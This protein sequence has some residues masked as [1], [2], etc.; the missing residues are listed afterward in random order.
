MLHHLKIAVTQIAFIRLRMVESL[1]SQSK[2]RSAWLTFTLLPPP[3]LVTAMV[4]NLTSCVIYKN[5]KPNKNRKIWRVKLGSSWNMVTKCYFL[6]FLKKRRFF[7][8]RVVLKQCLQSART[9]W[10]TELHSFLPFG[11]VVKKFPL[12]RTNSFKQLACLGQSIGDRVVLHSPTYKP[13]ESFLQ[14]CNQKAAQQLLQ[15]TDTQVLLQG[16]PEQKR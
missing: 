11:V 13:C 7:S 16:S 14:M 15:C 4:P 2:I 6:F 1:H 8:S 9:L 10:K 12:S 5:K 3:T